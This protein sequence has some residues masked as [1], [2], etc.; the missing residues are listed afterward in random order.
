[1]EGG[2]SW[3]LEPSVGARAH[4]QFEAEL[5]SQTGLSQQ[6]FML[7]PFCN[8]QPLKGYSQVPVMLLC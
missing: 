1:M 2:A 8:N 7:D 3:R 5:I 6:Y 4:V